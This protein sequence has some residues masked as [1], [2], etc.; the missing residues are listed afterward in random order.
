MERWR[1]GGGNVIKIDHSQDQTRLSVGWE[2]ETGG[3]GM[4]TFCVLL[5]QPDGQITCAIF[6]PLCQSPN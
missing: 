5:I 3:G 1:A 2:G 4:T 6:R